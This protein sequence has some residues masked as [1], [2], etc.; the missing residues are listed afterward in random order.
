MCN[1]LNNFRL[2]KSLIYDNIKC[3]ISLINKNFLKKLR[4]KK[5]L[6]QTNISIFIRNI[7]HD[8]HFTNDYHRLFIYLKNKINKKKA[9]AYFSRSVYCQ[10]LKDKAI[11]KYKHY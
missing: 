6:Q 4:L 2:T 5:R 3:T 11:D 8:K 7:N 1:L 10:E 9:I